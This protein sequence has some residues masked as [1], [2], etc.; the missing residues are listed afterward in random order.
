MAARAD[1]KMKGLRVFPPAP[2]G[3]DALAATKEDL[4]RHGLPQRPDPRTQP[5]LA[6]LW[7]QRARRYQGFEHLE[8]ELLPAD[9]PTEPAAAGFGLDP[10]TSCGFELTSFGAPITMVSGT[11]TVPNL[12][13]SPNTGLPNDFRTFFG[14]GFL[15]V[16]VEMTVDTAQDI[17]AL[18]RIHTG[19]QVAL[20]VSPGDAISAILCLTTDDGTAFYFLA[21]E[22]TSQTVNFVIETGFPPA[23]AIN[24]G[25]SRGS[26]FNGPPDPLARF[27][28]VYFDE[29][30]AW[31]TNGTRLLTDGVPTTMVDSNGS[32][33]AEPHKLNDFAFKALY[34]G[35]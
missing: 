12:N 21:N 23:V 33:L 26:Q 3:F 29:V 7:E 6:A 34:R 17:T 4:A 22:T 30:V 8:P 14:L 5:G 15:D 11:W 16:H 19:A 31:T 32:T 13:H 9:I 10:L 1:S 27:G 25:I 20:P 24:A 35:D 28:V 2:K 18:I